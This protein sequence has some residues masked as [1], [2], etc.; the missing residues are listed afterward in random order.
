M[1]NLS[2]LS[3]GDL[4]SRTEASLCGDKCFQPSSDNLFVWNLVA[5][6]AMVILLGLR[7]AEEPECQKFSVCSDQVSTCSLEQKLVNCATANLSEC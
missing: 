1:L 5:C 6:V 2:E 7:H 3:V 4:Q